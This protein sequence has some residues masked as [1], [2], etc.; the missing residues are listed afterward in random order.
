[1]PELLIIGAINVD[2]YAAFAN[3]PNIR[4]DVQIQTIPKER[5]SVCSSIHRSETSVPSC[6][7]STTDSGRMTSA[8]AME[9]IEASSPKWMILSIIESPGQSN[10]ILHHNM[11]PTTHLTTK[12]CKNILQRERS[13][14]CRKVSRAAAE[15]G[16][17][18]P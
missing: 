6:A 4:D 5:H 10:A 14:K 16:G 13:L 12:V 11:R 3:T 7:T 8:H 15:Q 2:H 18:I 9:A 17:P 1:M